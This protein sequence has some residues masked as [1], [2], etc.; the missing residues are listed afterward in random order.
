MYDVISATNSSPQTTEINAKA[1]AGTL[2]KWVNIGLAQAILFVVIMTIAEPPGKKWRPIMGG[3]LA[4]IL[5]YVQYVHAK[6]A[7]LSSSEPPTEDYK[8]VGPQGRERGRYA[9]RYPSNA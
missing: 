4:S 3:G 1:R 8:D 7:G 6:N 5:L 9:A 2:M